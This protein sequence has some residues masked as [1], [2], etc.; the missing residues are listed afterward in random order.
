MGPPPPASKPG[1]AGRSRDP[2]PSVR[3]PRGE[4]CDTSRVKPVL[5]VGNKNYSSWS[6]R[7]WLVLT[8]AG[9][10]FETRV[11]KLGGEGYLKRKVPG[12]LAISPS[13][14]VPALHVGG[15]VIGDSLAISEWAAEHVPSLWPADPLVRAHARSAACEMHSSFGALRS[16]MPCNIR[17][18]T[19]AKPTNEDVLSDIA[20]VQQIW[21]TLRARFGAG[22]AYLFGKEP[23]IADAF[24]TPVA[25]RFRT[26]GVKLEPDAQ[27]YAD[28]LLSNDAF[29][30]WEAEAVAEPFG[31]PEWD[32]VEVK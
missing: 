2:G 27:R 9:L 22:G 4:T 30:V 7:P 28:T 15:D 31:M 18:R 14:T 19:Q 5:Y 16:A 29:R 10:D 24:Y 17:R 25:T 21:T 11:V 1:G 26:Y 13:G 6:L 8:W 3:A 12:V 20:R 32:R 23:C